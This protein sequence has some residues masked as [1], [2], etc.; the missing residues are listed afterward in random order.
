MTL[1]RPSRPPLRNFKLTPAQQILLLHVASSY[2][3]G[4]AALFST[5]LRRSERHGLSQRIPLL[6]LQYQLVQLAQEHSHPDE[7][8]RFLAGR[9][10][11]RPCS[12]EPA[13]RR[14]RRCRHTPRL[15]DAARIALAFAIRDSVAHSCRAVKR[16]D[17]SVTTLRPANRNPSTFHHL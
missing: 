4:R 8:I 17:S 7:D 16:F 3:G 14:Q 12:R 6:R 13:Q 2:A 1:V 11:L 5:D 15:A 10:W 9:V